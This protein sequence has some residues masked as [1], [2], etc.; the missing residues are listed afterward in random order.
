ME[1]FWK[2]L[3]Q[4]LRMFRRSPGFTVTALLA[5]ALGIGANTAIFSVVN[6]VLLK[7]VTVPEPE[8]VVVFVTTNKEG[9]GA[10][11]SDIK[12]N[13]WRRQTNIFENVSGS[14]W[15][16]FTLTG[17]DRPVRV[18]AECVTAG[19]LALFGL[20][21]V[22][23]R[24]FLAGEE[25]P[26]GPRAVVLSNAFWKKVLHGDPGIVGKSISLSDA[27]Y[28]VVGIMADGVVIEDGEKPD[29]W[30]PFPIDPNSNN[31]VHYF[32]AEGRLRR[33]VTTEMANA[34][35]KLTTQEFRRLYPKALS[36]S[37]GDVF[38][39]QPLRDYLVKD[40]RASL[41]TLAAAVG[42]VLLIACANVANLLLMRAEGRR[43]EV[44]IRVAVGA[45]RARIVRQ[46]LTES[47]LLAAAGAVCGLALGA[48]GIHLLLAAH[49][50][51]LPRL[52]EKGANVALDWRVLAF[53]V[54]AAAGTGLV[55]GLIP[56]LQVS[57][58]D[59]SRGMKGAGGRVRSLLAIVEMS[60]AI[61]LLIGASLFIRTLLA[62]RSV[63]P[64]F[65]P[66]G[67][68]VTQTLLEPRREERVLRRVEAIPGVDGAA[69]TG[70]LPLE[71]GF[72]SLTITIPG[73]PLEG[74]SHGN[75]R[76][77][78][79]SPGYFDV[80]KI[81][82]L[83]GRVFTRA[84][85]GDAPAVAV[86]NRA[87]ARQ[88]WPDSDPIDDRLVIGRGLGQNFEEPPRQVVG[89]VGDVHD[90]ALGTDPLPAVFVPFAQ[91]PNT[92][93]LGM[94]VVVRTRGNSHATDAAIPSEVQNAAG[95]PPV[96]AMRRMQAILV[97]STARQDFRMLLMSI[98]AG[99]AAVLAAIGIYGL[100]GYS[101]QQRTREIGIR[102]AL[103][104][105][106]SAVRNMVI[107][108]GMRLAAA[109]AGLGLATAFYLT[110]F[111]AGFLYGVTALDPLVFL[112]VP[113]LLAGVALLA[114]WG[115]ALRAARVDPL[116]A[117]RHE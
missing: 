107:R 102:M 113:V 88:F 9:G 16:N 4:A 112:A 2:D 92:R 117:L 13:L 38:S 22:H 78:T 70:L 53:T 108:Q 48:T 93:A 42:F 1:S 5:L 111:L 24:G 58:A 7:P 50:V 23:G 76:W 75:A 47:A 101:V 98:F 6:T 83:R 82:L 94:W 19:Y 80:L 62:L 8:R 86:I 52:G 33:G 17:T 97:Q 73:R 27:S 28:Q 114:V 89:I 12:F 115:P 14:H 21:V 20:P 68:V 51:D 66:R 35:L 31:Q 109:G 30:L 72:N 34:Q 96:P 40:V 54:L 116:R 71:G 64:G 15:A 67:V 99:L 65:D 105:Q 91:R 46:F 32:R 85:R 61:V 11:A 56:A 49:A 84:D 95:G 26:D 3:R 18:D 87:M 55:F 25:Q 74:L 57:R 36:T 45:S 81:P 39:V 60:M 106:A 100:M 110:R 103:G 59:L 77:M 10:F 29:V 41:L 63:N 43:R 69:L 37:R 79:I 44:A 104:A 90:D